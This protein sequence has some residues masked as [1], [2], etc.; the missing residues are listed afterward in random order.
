MIIV[1]KFWATYDYYFSHINISV[2]FGGQEL[3]LFFHMR[4]LMHQELPQPHRKMQSL[5]LSLGRQTQELPLVT[6][7]LDN[8]VTE[9]DPKP[10]HC[11]QF[12]G[13]K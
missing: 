4:N 5:N 1:V 3:F 10:Q 6:T 2:T 11:F 12:Y 9:Q 7:N 13:M 8:I